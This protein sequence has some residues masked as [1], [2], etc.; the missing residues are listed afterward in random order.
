MEEE[1]STG[2]MVA[3]GVLLTAG[4]IVG[5]IMLQNLFAYKVLEKATTQPPIAFPTVTY[6]MSSV[7]TPWAVG[8]P[9]YL[10]GLYDM[11]TPTPY[12][13]DVIVVNR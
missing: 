9:W 5:F 11:S 13:G 6:P 1:G 8:T 3:L 10:T 2:F 12:G 7:L 4:A